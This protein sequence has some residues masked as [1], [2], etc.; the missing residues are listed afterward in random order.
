MCFLPFPLAKSMDHF[1]FVGPIVTGIGYLNML[2]LWLMP[3]LQKDRE[4]FIFQ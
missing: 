2:P 1:F 4:D 3:Q